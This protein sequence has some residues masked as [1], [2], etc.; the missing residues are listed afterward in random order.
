MQEPILILKAFYINLYN[1]I[2]S[3]AYTSNIIVNAGGWT[4]G[5]STYFFITGCISLLT[6]LILMLNKKISSIIFYYGIHK[7][8]FIYTIF[9]FMGTVLTLTV[10][11]I[12]TILFTFILL[13][14]LI[15]NKLLGLKSNIKSNEKLDFIVSKAEATKDS[16]LIENSDKVIKKK[17]KEKILGLKIVTEEEKSLEKFNNNA[18]ITKDYNT[19]ISNII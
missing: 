15:N 16:G 9:T 4:I 14:Y 3:W 10:K 11:W 12:F 17:E 5:Y 13:E 18:D 19:M 1:D 7:T 6:P 2:Q 8:G